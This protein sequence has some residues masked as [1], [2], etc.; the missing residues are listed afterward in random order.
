M[1][2]S[3]SDE[4]RASPQ[5]SA[6][7]APRTGSARSGADARGRGQV[8][9][10]PRRM[11]VIAALAVA[12]VSA[13]AQ[14]TVPHAASA[15]ARANPG[16]AADAVTPAGLPAIGKWMIDRDGGIAHWLGEL[17]RGKPLREPI[18]VI[19]V[20]VAAESAADAKRRLVAAATAAGYPVRFGHST[21][22]RAFIGGQ[23]YAQLPAGRDDAFSDRIFELSNNHGRLFGPHRTG[24]VYVSTGAFS[25]EALRPLHSPAHGYASF[26]RA[27]DD[28]SQ[29]LDRKTTFKLSGFVDLANAIAGGAEVTTGD[30]DGLAVLLRAVR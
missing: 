21:G 18:N 27:R 1:H 28:F 9:R 19:L 8:F 29:N 4:R 7:S 10:N 30:H 20:D 2:F 22:Y 26:N 6:A 16:A 24:D 15:Q 12:A 17:Y 3:P 11:A 25:R 23:L 5:D 14:Q 13:P